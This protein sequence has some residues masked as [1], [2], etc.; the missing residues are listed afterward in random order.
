M[1]GFA[2]LYA[3][4]DATTSTAAKVAAMAAYFAEAP[5]ADAAWGVYFLTGQRLKRL[6]GPRKLRAWVGEVVGLPPALVDESYAHVGDLAETIALL[7]DTHRG[8]PCAAASDRALHRWVEQVLH[9]LAGQDE[10]RQRAA[11][12]DAW[13]Q[14]PSAELFLF[15][16]LLTGGLR[17]GVSRK[18]VTRALARASGVEA[19]EIA[20]RLM[21]EWQPSAAGFQALV[22]PRSDA[23]ER[24][25]GQPFPYYLA[26][27]VDGDP[28]A[29]LGERDAWLAE[30]KW[31]GIR[32][33]LIRRAGEV[34][35]WSRGEE[36]VTEGFPE[37][38][39]AARALPD[40]LVLDGEI[41][42]L[43]S[44]AGPAVQP[45][46]FADL[47]RRLNRKR[48]GKTL[49]A[50][51]PVGF[52]AYDLLEQGGR[53][54][55][56]EP[57]AARRDRLEAALAAPPEGLLLSPLVAGATWAELADLRASA[58]D[59][60]TEGLMLK[61]RDAPYQVGRVRGGWWKWKLDPL[62][63]DA[64]L[65]YAQAGHGRRATLFT[66]YTFA[67]WD[68]DALVPVAKAYSG[69]DDAQIQELD[70]WIRRNTVE[71]FGPVRSVPAHH[72]FEI[73]FEGVRESKRHKAGVAVR[74]PR[75]SRWRR[76]KTPQQADALADVRALLPHR[77]S[78][79]S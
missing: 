32:G 20:H 76:D 16:K 26:S 14:L 17:V 68:G 40:G 19:A 53:D 13:D 50:Q 41:L 38:V 4:L 23:A 34:F 1:R 44:L 15:N 46:P 57:Q 54:V 30:W 8:P 72:V 55:R 58:R 49:L 67:V 45:R 75:I 60:A 63:I 21:G 29:A 27:P 25:P 37:I 65:I 9:P 22:A 7:F 62:T 69:L 36:L 59:R 71:K 78:R 66:D 43:E 5:P 24:P 33:Q 28:A 61:H 47:Q 64:V 2:A 77:L 12:I 74:F 51:V 56:S 6:V 35:L 10:A 18:L 31:D 11:V 42:A 73:A 79:S 3:E 70:R 48:V 39:Q 52:V